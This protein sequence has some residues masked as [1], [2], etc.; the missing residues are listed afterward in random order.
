MA[1]CWL[2]DRLVGRDQ[3]VTCQEK[4]L[5]NQTSLFRFSGSYPF[6]AWG[7][8]WDMDIPP[9][10]PWKLHF[11]QLSDLV[12]LQEY[13]ADVDWRLADMNQ[14][15]QLSCSL[16]SLTVPVRYPDDCGILAKELKR[17]H[18]LESLTIL[19]LP[20][21][22]EF[23]DVF[24]LLA[25][26]L[27]ARASSLRSLAIELTAHSRPYSWDTDDF[28]IPEPDEMDKYFRALFP[29]PVKNITSTC[30]VHPYCW[31]RAGLQE[32]ETVFQLTY[33]GLQH[34]GVPWD[35]FRDTFS[36]EHIKDLCLPNTEVDAEVWTDL[37]GTVDLRSLTHIDYD[38]LTPQL[39]DFLGSQEN[40]E[41]LS[42]SKPLP[43]R[44]FL[45]V[46]SL[47]P[48]TSPWYQT[49]IIEAGEPEHED[50]LQLTMVALRNLPKL[51][52]LSIPADMYDIS[53][54]HLQNLG[55]AFPKL[56]RIELALNYSDLVSHD[57][58][59]LPQFLTY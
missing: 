32:M 3:Y 43:D 40:L 42:F 49:G 34:F 48:A 1:R 5:C 39:V 13:R 54:L 17:L 45:G 23:V 46:A 31:N 36:K 28:V 24:P 4:K 18:R 38:I 50:L 6:T 21:L 11:G 10:D 47:G 8:L 14:V 55:S 35:A 16:K 58:Y 57:T 30:G 26:G 20:I 56:E 44:E 29:K 25:E 52:S 33:L 59:S 2:D 19:S 53:C 15:V 51:K 12:N 37:K 27:T 9:P 22:D 41:T 7:Q